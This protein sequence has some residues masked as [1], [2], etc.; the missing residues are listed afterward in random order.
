MARRRRSKRGGS[1]GFRVDMTEAKLFGILF[2]QYNGPATVTKLSNRDLGG[3]AQEWGKGDLINVGIQSI[4][5][6]GVAAIRRKFGAYVQPI[7]S[8]WISLRG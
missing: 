8:K 6:G 5:A 1:K 7:K 3:A 2:S 4:T